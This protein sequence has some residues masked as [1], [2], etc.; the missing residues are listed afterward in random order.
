LAVDDRQYLSF[1]RYLSSIRNFGGT[2]VTM[3]EKARPVQGIGRLLYPYG[4]A[5]YAAWRD[6]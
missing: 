2:L 6:G 5:W 3:I 4:G 1:G